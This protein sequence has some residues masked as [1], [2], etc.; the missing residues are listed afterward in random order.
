[1]ALHEHI[2]DHDGQGSQRSS[3]HKGAPAVAHF[4]IQKLL[5]P[6]GER[7][8]LRLGQHQQRPE[9]EV[10]RLDNG[11]NADGGDGA[12]AQ[13]EGD[14]AHRP[15]GTRAFNLRTLIICAWHA[16]DVLIQIKE[17]CGVCRV[18]QDHRG[19]CVEQ[20]HVADKDVVGDHC[21]LE[22][23]DHCDQQEVED[24]G[25]EL[26]VVVAQRKR[27]QK[28]N[29]NLQDG[30]AGRRGQAV[31]EPVADV[32]GG[33]DLAVMIQRKLLGDQV[34]FCGEQFARAL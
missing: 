28:R 30:D 2:N 33:E 16:A 9:I 12:F 31:L 29:Q 15:E 27:G 20:L 6:Y 24:R 21:H 17:G 11:E 19:P 3:R 26:R 14:I 34:N 10:P 22:R 25:I 1:M 8:A 23:N 4:E 13:A 7:A 32:V 5:E 18:G